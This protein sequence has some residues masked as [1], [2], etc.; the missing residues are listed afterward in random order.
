MAD[1]CS[2][3]KAG[4]PSVRATTLQRYYGTYVDYLYSISYTLYLISYIFSPLLLSCS[5]QL[6]RRREVMLCES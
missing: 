1:F 6:A 4:S 2:V 5:G 3:L